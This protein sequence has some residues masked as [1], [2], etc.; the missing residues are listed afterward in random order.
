MVSAA[1]T[2]KAWQKQREKLR[3]A[4]FL[5]YAAP[6]LRHLTL[7]YKTEITVESN[8]TWAIVASFRPHLMI[9]SYSMLQYIVTVYRGA[10]GTARP[11]RLRTAY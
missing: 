5:Y 1:E 3:I 8:A 6:G 9:G 10:H 2:S 4:D 11:Y 7:R